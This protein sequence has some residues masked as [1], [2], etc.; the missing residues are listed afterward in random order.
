MKVI[1]IGSGP[2]GYPAALKLKALGADVKIIENLDF[3]GTCLNRGCI[4]SKAILEIAHR[5]HNFEEILKFTKNE[6]QIPEFNWDKIRNHKNEVVLKIRNSL[7]KLFQLKKIEIIRGFASFKS[8]N[9]ISVKTKEGEIIYEFDYAIIATGTK[10]AYPPPFDL[11]KEKLTDSD[12]IFDIPNFPQKLTIIGAG[13]IGL[14]LACFFNAMGSN[15][16]IV[17]ILNEIL[18]NEEQQI[19]KFLKTSFEQRGIKFHLGVKTQNIIFEGN[20]KILELENGENIESDEILVSTGRKADFSELDL[21]KA[22]IEY[23]KWIKVDNNLKTTNPKVYAIGDINGISLLAHSA[24]R[25][26]EIA[27]ENIMGKNKIFDSHIVPNCIYTWPEIASVGFR[28]KELE[29]KGIKTKI[30]RSY[31][32]TLG[33]AISSLNT[34]G[35]CQIITDE[36]DI[37]L[38]AQIIGGPA[39]EIIHILSL[40]IKNKMKINELNSI[41]FAHPT[42]SEIIKE[43]LNK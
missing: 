22:G 10:P 25:Q 4:P 30:K 35:M 27:A 2:G 21:Q 18:P 24:E 32:Q 41:I 11:Y 19:T 20:K 38:G 36:N 43:A 8:E 23:Q 40:A 34:D 15:V 39:T 33:R 16:E 9:Q 31:F 6:I 17:E 26:G 13:V 5:K 14:E 12:K 1:I 7:E 29:E 28:K 42:M 37:I 3:G